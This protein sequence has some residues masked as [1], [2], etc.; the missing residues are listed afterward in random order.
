MLLKEIGIHFCV[1]RAVAGSTYSYL[2]TLLH[3]D[4]VDCG[5]DEKFELHMLHIRV[6][7]NFRYDSPKAQ[8]SLYF[9]AFGAFL[10]FLK[11]Q[12]GS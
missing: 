1:F 10:H 3:T 6:M 2:N 12:W 7:G 5:W 11:I 8:G 9:E 4:C